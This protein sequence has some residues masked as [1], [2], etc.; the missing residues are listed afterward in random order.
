MPINMA[1]FCPPALHP[2]LLWLGKLKNWYDI[3]PGRLIGGLPSTDMSVKSAAFTGSPHE[4]LVRVI[5]RFKNEGDIGSVLYL[6]AMSRL[7][8]DGPKLFSPTEEQ[9]EAMEHVTLDIPVADFR[10][11]YPAIVVSVPPGCRRRLADNFS[12]HPSR[13][14]QGLIVRSMPEFKFVSG[15]VKFPRTEN[16]FLFQDQPLN[17]TI[18]AAITRQIPSSHQDEGEPGDFPLSTVC[19]R[20][21]LNLALM[22][23]HYGCRLAGPADPAE[24]DKHR[25]KKHLRHL[26]AADFTTVEMTQTV[27]IRNHQYSGTEIKG[28]GGPMRPHW[29]RGHWRAA[30]GRAADR[31]AG[32][33]VPLV[34][35]RP[36]LVRPDRVAGDPA[37]ITTEYTAE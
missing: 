7:L 1:Y 17:P 13:S 14:P 3:T 12:V 22:M 16:S 33:Q 28:H 24:Y 30:P 10:S 6:E 23:T 37:G 20:V 36:C 26:A 34:F 21:A 11:P 27:V 9:W 4:D 35:V 31:A 18:E 19:C 29:R 8:A 5:G 32:M 15:W 25:K 2:G